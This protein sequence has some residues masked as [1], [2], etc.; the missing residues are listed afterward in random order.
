MRPVLR[1]LGTRYG[2]ALLLALLVLGVLGITRALAGPDRS[3][4]VQPVVEPSRTFASTDPTAGNDSLL[5]P[6]SP[7][8]PTTS[9][10]A[11]GPETVAGDF[12]QGWLK[13][14]GVTPE[15]WRSSFARYATQV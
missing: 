11:A 9:P 1:L 5:A 8:P 13:H 6:E 14:D 3:S 15:Q 4:A 2:M 12:L 7:S 10:G